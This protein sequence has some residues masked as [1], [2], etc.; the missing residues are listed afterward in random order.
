MAR[1]SLSLLG[2]L[3]VRLD[4][5]PITALAYD[6]VWALLAYLAVEA[7]RPHR[8]DALI[9]LLW[10]EQ[11][12]HAA[13]TN[14]RQALTQLR[15]ALG[16]HT[17]QPPFLLIA[18]ETIQFN[19]SSD[20]DL[21]VARFTTLL[22]ACDAHP[23]RHPETCT[24][25]ARR[26]AEAAELYRG[27]FLEE[28]FLADAAPF[29]EWA[30]VKRE[31]LRDRV[32]SSLVYLADYHERRG[33]Y[34]DVR[35]YAR[36]QLELDP[37]HDAAHRRLM[38]VLALL[39]QRSAA[40]SQYERCCRVLA[41]ELGVAPEAETTALYEQ[42]KWGNGQAAGCVERPP[43]NLHEHTP[44][45]AFI[46]RE[47]ELAQLAER[48]ERRD[49]RLLTLAG[50]GGIGKTRLALQV[51]AELCDSFIDGVWFVPL[52]A[53]SDPA[54]MVTSIAE[55]F[56]ITESAGQPLMMHLKRYL[57]AK[58]FLL[59]LDNFEQ[60]V[61]AGPL[62]A[63]LLASAPHLTV[64]ITSRAVLHLSGEQ[65]FEVPPLALPDR[66]HLRAPDQLTRY[67]AVRL[68]IE[69]ARAV[70]PGFEVT[71]RNA[72]AVAEICYRL[73]GLP[74]AIELAAARIKLF[75]PA[76][77]LTRLNRRLLLLT[78]GARNLPLRQQTLRNTIEW[79]YDLLEASEQTLFRRLGV[80]M[81]GC[82]L[83]GAEAICNAEGDLPMRVIDGITALVDKSLLR[84]EEDEDGEPRFVMLET[85][86]EY[87]LE[88]LV[89][90]G[91]A[92]NVGRWHVDYYLALAEQ[93]APALRAGQQ[94]AWLDRL[95]ADH[96]NLRAALDWC[97]E[98]REAERGLRLGSTVWRLWFW[99]GHI[100]E[101]RTYL[102]A[103][104]TLA[105]ARHPT[106]A[107]VRALTAAGVLARLQYDYA[108]ARGLLEES[109]AA[110]RKLGDEVEIAD[111]LS[112]LGFVVHLQGD[113]A[114]ARALYE[115]S[116]ALFRVRGA[117][118]GTARALAPLGWIALYQ[119]DDVTARARFEESLATFQQLGD[120]ARSG[121]A[122][123]GLGEVARSQGDY[124]RAVRLYEA[125]LA[126][127]QELGD[128]SMEALL[129][130][131]LGFVR[132][133]QSDHDRSMTLFRKSLAL[134]QQLEDQV[135]I[136]Y[137]LIGL[138][139]LAATR[140]RP[141]RAVRLLAAAETLRAPLDGD[142]N[143]ADRTQFEHNL[144]VARSQLDDATFAAAWDDGQT[145]HLDQ[146]IAE[147]LDNLAPA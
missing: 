8:R 112:H 39:G 67:E 18:R 61:D 54:L 99:H 105:P 98:N 9:G 36:Q 97:L 126:I 81:G 109:L 131:H 108:A 142:M 47:A 86:R 59:V 76:A 41:E 78:G 44:P 42:I 124:A 83:A 88:R 43:T 15:Q 64:I 130:Q 120:T 85:I 10:P 132:Y 3:E 68:F 87:A 136:A 4:G 19:R 147:A 101:G 139:G 125:S 102:A 144:T 117:R 23:H 106:L 133:N 40:L 141:E 110:C 2:P 34:E 45:T 22:A 114:T 111:V 71:S 26:R 20:Y 96:A 100:T 31:G 28:F 75:P 129:L 143:P 37:W 57:G 63:E 79:S 145:M 30:L 14:L 95:E 7:D 21:D 93:A 66:R 48:L 140:G 103:I 29:E 6:K 27:G 70:K 134:G 127:A 121:E 146:A 49:C 77:L 11:P 138:A 52:A 56:G 24:T 82:T 135:T 115:Q 91:E 1:L 16:D 58:E 46:G 73:D 55:T 51:A 123:L 94:A 89:E 62:V 84:P 69:R 38:R 116:A 104:L 90:H 17:T 5:Q 32:L 53:I 128:T 92:E 60:V 25:C 118:S 13:R 72:S 12:D 74:L 113:L 50:P 122:L 35:R 137:A 107:R 33:A 65:E 119:G 80:F